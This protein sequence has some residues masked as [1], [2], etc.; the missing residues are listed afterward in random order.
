MID[1]EFETKMTPQEHDLRFKPIPKLLLQLAIPMIVAQVVNALYNIVDRIYIGNIPGHGST[2]LTAVGLSFAAIILINACTV[3]IGAGGSP[4]LSIQ[5][6][7]KN[8]EKASEILN[9]SLVY[10][11]GLAVIIIPLIYFGQDYFLPYFGASDQTFQP[12]KDYLSIYVLGTPFVMISLGMNFFINAQG[13]ARQGMISVLIGAVAN[14]ILDPIF[15]F[16]FNM[17]VK[18]AAIATVLAQGLS[19]AYVI[20]ILTRPH[21]AVRLNLK[22]ILQTR[23][24]NLAHITALGVSP[25]VMQSTE[26]ILLIIQNFVLQREGGDLALGAMVIFGSITQFLILPMTGLTLGAQAITSYNFGA[27]LVDRVREN[28]RIVVRYAT[29]W[30]V[31]MQLIVSLFP[32]VFLRIFSQDATLLNYAGP[33][34]PLY[35]GGIFL[36]GFQSTFQTSFIALNQAKISSFLAI[37][38]KGVLLIPLIL[39][40]PIWFDAFGVFLARPI[41]DSLAALTTTAFFLYHFPRLLKE[42]TAQLSDHKGA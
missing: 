23:G 38:R 16:G 17:N 39:I 32:N 35:I 21:I 20:Y 4:L 6:G 13:L 42:R 34:L 8:Q 40:L 14:I 1:V 28:I 7:E 26:G 31:S 27:G 37:V 15:I 5:L 18:G 9:E 30:V 22:K 36:A 3:L 12:A 10:L 2:L 29:I 25:F 41:A 24:K 33:L 11:L 19:A